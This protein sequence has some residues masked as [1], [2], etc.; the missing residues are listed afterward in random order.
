[1]Q[2][3]A[4]N[5]VQI[6]LRS[7]QFCNRLSE[8]GVC[9][10]KSQNLDWPHCSDLAR[11][12]IQ[13]GNGKHHMKQ[14][15]ATA[16]AAWVSISAPLQAQSTD[17]VVVELFTSQGCSSC[18]AADALL[19]KLSADSDVIA[20]SLHV[21]YWDYL[22]WKDKFAS[23]QFTAR[24]KAYAHYARDK[25]VYTP[26]MVIQGQ[27]RLVG[28]RGGEV[29]EAIRQHVGKAQNDVLR[30][31]R[32]GNTLTIRAEPVASES[33][34]I[35]VQ[36]VRFTPSESVVIKRGEN[37]GKTITYHNIVRSWQVIGKWDGRSPLLLQ[38][39]T[40][41]TAPIAVILQVDGP[42]EILAAAVLR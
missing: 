34:P 33:G 37:A 35:R 24:Q 8:S 27:A 40:T 10:A 21:D 29:D 32:S 7:K 42:A 39:E 23:P 1:M 36:L 5:P 13:E 15:L 9:N 6:S 3:Y 26:Q 12:K 28:N 20:L 41:G 14:F 22:G 2:L 16:C 38:A 18:P 30:L 31:E 25:M 4:E 17:A 19:A 11:E